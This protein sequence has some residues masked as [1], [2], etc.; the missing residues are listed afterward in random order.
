L[1]IREIHDVVAGIELAQQLHAV[2]FVHPGRHLAAVEA[3]WD[4][5]VDGEGVILAEEVVGSGMGTL[6]STLLHPIHHAEGGHQFAAGM[7]RNGELATGGF[8][9]C[10]RKSLGCAVDRV[11]RLGEA[12]RQAPADR[13][14]R[15]GMNRRRCT[16]SQD[17]GNAGVLQKL[18]TFHV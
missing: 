9:D 17:A 6:D 11:E 14:R 12:R 3:E 16:G 13:R 15:L 18:A 4:R 7:D 2:A 8:A 5:A 10:L 1:P